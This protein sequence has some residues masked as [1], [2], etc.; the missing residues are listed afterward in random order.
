M[1]FARKEKRNKWITEK[2]MKAFCLKNNNETVQ[3]ID[4]IIDSP[5]SYDEAEKNAVSFK[6]QN[7]LFPV[8]G[9][10]DMIKMKEA[11]GRLQDDSDIRYLKQKNE[12]K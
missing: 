12:E 1:D 2:N 3:E 6:L 7:Q 11:A 9:I 8:A 4:I 10:K 5:V